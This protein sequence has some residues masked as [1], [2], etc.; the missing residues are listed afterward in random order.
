MFRTAPK[1][2]CTPPV[3]SFRNTS[4]LDTFF[5]WMTM[6]RPGKKGSPLRY[7]STL[8][9]A[10]CESQDALVPELLMLL[11]AP[12]LLPQPEPPA[13][14]GWGELPP[15]IPSGPDTA[16]MGTPPGQRSRLAGA[17]AQPYVACTQRL[18]PGNQRAAPAA[19]GA[20]C[21]ERRPERK[22]AAWHSG[23][24][25]RDTGCRAPAASGGFILRLCHDGKPYRPAFL[26]KLPRVCPAFPQEPARPRGTAG[27]SAGSGVPR[28]GRGGRGNGIPARERGRSPLC[29]LPF[30]LPPR[31]GTPCGRGAV[32]PERKRKCP[33]M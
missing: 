19:G 32:K 10:G 5:S 11:L 25:S 21:G 9:T 16:H 28:E 29:L 4:K 24:H 2:A 8:F 26:G 14:V 17:W 1:G 30:P 22:N 3:T 6:R 12:R 20:Q 31:S 18:L 27:R 33:H 13:P 7:T 23:R 15:G